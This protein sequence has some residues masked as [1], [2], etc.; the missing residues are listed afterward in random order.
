MDNSQKIVEKLIEAVMN[1]NNESAGK[2]LNAYI[3]NRLVDKIKQVNKTEH[4][5]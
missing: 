3:N 2:Q 1:K 5:I 4:L